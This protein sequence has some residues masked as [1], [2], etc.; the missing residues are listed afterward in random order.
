MITSLEFIEAEP[1]DL[2]EM[3]CAGFLENKN[4]VFKYDDQEKCAQCGNCNKPGQARDV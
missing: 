1:V 3:F 4:I 2:D